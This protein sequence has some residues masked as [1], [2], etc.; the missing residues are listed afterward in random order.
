MQSV[1]AWLKKRKEQ[2]RKEEKGRKGKTARKIKKRKAEKIKKRKSKDYNFWYQFNARLSII[3]GCPG[4]MTQHTLVLVP[5]CYGK[6]GMQH[7]VDN[8]PGHQPRNRRVDSIAVCDYQ[9]ILSIYF[10]RNVLWPSK[11]CSVVHGDQQLSRH[12]QV[13]AL[14]HDLGVLHERCCARHPCTSCKSAA[15]TCQLYT[16]VC[17]YK[18]A[19][20]AFML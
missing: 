5:V 14:I 11:G 8:G 20:Y 15:Y 6:A 17:T 4:S 18:Q 1:P 12:P 3:P 13:S 2:E 10:I 9:H 16:W 7:R 19:S